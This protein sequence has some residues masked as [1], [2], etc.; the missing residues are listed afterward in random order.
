MYEMIAAASLVA[1]KT[2]K[3]T[4]D[5]FYNEF[6]RQPFYERWLDRWSALVSATD[7]TGCNGRDLCRDANMRTAA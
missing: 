2:D 3:M 4:E 6:G 7:K 1:S 5:Q